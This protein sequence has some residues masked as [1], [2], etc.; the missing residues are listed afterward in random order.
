[1]NSPLWSD[2]SSYEG[3]WYNNY[4]NGYGIYKYSDGSIYVGSWHFN[5]MEGLG[6][7]T[8]PS[9]RIYFG[10]FKNNV[11]AGF[12]VLF[13]NEEQKAYIGFWENN[14]QNGFGQFIN[15]DKSIYGVWKD[16]KL[17]NKIQTKSEF[18]NNLTN[19]GQI[20][21]NIFTASNFTEFNERM[22]N[23]TLSY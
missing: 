12:G 7:Y 21:F 4:L 11:K 14:K 1:M 13:R 2:K 16:G 8:T 22:T 18:F 19:S 5:K 6:E 15:E 9:N 17:I 10:F 23:Y 3:Q 20:C